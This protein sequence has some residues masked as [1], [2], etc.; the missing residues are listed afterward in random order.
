[1]YLAE[2]Y[3]LFRLSV[4]LPAILTDGNGFSGNKL[5]IKFV[6]LSGI[7]VPPISIDFLFSKFPVK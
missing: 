4:L 2:T 6:L 7:T 1:M 5:G 3:L